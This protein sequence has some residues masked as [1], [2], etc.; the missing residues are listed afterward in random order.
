MTKPTDLSIL[1]RD[2]HDMAGY[3]KLLANP[4]RLLMLCQMDERE[5]S[6]GELTEISG[7]SQSA[8]SQHLA[9]FRKQGIVSLRGEAQTRYY[10]LADPKMQRIIAALCEA[11]SEA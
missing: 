8:V 3:L 7:L 10:T 1:K 6:V 11:C 5:V 9:R 4:E 2:A